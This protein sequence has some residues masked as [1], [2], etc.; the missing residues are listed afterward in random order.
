MKNAIGIKLDVPF[1]DKE[2][3]KRSGLK[4]DAIHKT[5]YY[6]LDDNLKSISN[7][8]KPDLLVF[9][10][11]KP[12][13]KNIKRYFLQIRQGYKCHKCDGEMNIVILFEKQPKNRTHTK[14]HE[15]ALVWEK[16]KSF[17]AFANSLYISMKFSR[18]SIIEESY[19][20]HI[21]PRCN[22]IQGDYYVYV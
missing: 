2:L 19:A 12:S 14:I 15:Y 10:T 13:S 6:P 20:L 22:A 3:A 16:P 7:W 5:W 18:T 11:T 4:W 9:S 8:I 1:T 17:V 21:C